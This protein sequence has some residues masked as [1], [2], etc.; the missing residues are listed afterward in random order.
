MNLMAGHLFD[1]WDSVS[2]QHGLQEMRNTRT[3]DTAL[4]V[5]PIGVDIQILRVD[6]ISKWVIINSNSKKAKE[7]WETLALMEDA[8]WY[9]E[10]MEPLESDWPVFEFLL[11]HI[12]IMWPQTCN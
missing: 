5:T 3:G 9:D 4:S 10:R 11:Q 2:C 8:S 6:E 7:C 12:L 1:Y